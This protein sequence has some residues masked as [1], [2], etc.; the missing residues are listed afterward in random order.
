MT[1]TNYS[2]KLF[3]EYKE[4]NK[5]LKDNNLG[6]YKEYIVSDQWKTIRSNKIKHTNYCEICGSK[7]YLNVHHLEYSCIGQ[8]NTNYLITLCHNCHTLAHA[9]HSAFPELSVK[10]A[11]N[12]TKIVKKYII[13]LNN[14]SHNIETKEIVNKNSIKVKKEMR[15]SRKNIYLKPKKENPH[16]SIFKFQ[17]LVNEIKKGSV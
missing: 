10:Q 13:A 9:I 7:T 15:K 12:K 5:I 11:T 6:T 16:A 3:T 8:L 2:S 17:S 4:R 1:K 14:G